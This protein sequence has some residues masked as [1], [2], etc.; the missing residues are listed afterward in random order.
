MAVE[1]LISEGCSDIFL[2]GSLA[3]NNVREGSDIDIAVQGCPRG[4]FFHIWGRLFRN[5]DYPVDLV[6]LDRD[7]AFSNYLKKEGELLQIG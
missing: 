3:E 6:S 5:L 4:K 7:D 2:F 1:I